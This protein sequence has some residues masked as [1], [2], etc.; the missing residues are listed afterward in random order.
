VP[1][2]KC[3]R[4]SRVRCASPKVLTVSRPRKRGTRRS[5]G[6]SPLR[7]CGRPMRRPGLSTTVEAIR[8]Q[9]WDGL[10]TMQNTAT[11]TIRYAGGYGR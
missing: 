3:A 10:M 5:K 9:G 2:L 8:Q 7:Q 4:P 1:F 11:G 6:P